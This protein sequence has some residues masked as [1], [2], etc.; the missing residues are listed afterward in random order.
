[1]WHAIGLMKKAGCSIIGTDEGRDDA[2]ARTLM[3]HKNY[4]IILASAKICRAP[5]GEVFGYPASRVRVCTLPRADI[6]TDLKYAS[7]KNV[8]IKEYHPQMA[9][10]E[11]ILYI[12][13]YRKDETTLQAKLEELEAAVDYERYNLIVK[14]HPLSSAH[15]ADRRVI[16]DENFSSM[17]MLFAADHVITDYSG[18]VFEALLAGKPVYYYAFDYDE[19]RDK[20]GWF[21]DYEAEIP[22]EILGSG[23]DVCRAISR[24]E[25]DRARSEA[26]LK[27]YVEMPKERCVDN[28]AD[29]VIAGMGKT[30]I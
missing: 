14:L 26:F 9:K 22:G 11:N 29:I 3:M 4:D 1:M 18:M 16:I 8:E 10:K 24:G 17:E 19:Y 28:L 25:Y 12:P 23:A 30:M 15:P 20:R 2:L 6:L 21:I 7:E 27:K 13:T 5:M